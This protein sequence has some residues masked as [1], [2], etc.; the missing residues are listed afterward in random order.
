MIMTS[1]SRL[2]V[3]IASVGLSCASPMTSEDVWECTF[4]GL[5][6]N[7]QTQSRFIVSGQ[8]LLQEGGGFEPFQILENSRDALVAV[9]GGTREIYEKGNQVVSE[10]VQIK[11]S[12]GAFCSWLSPSMA[13]TAEPVVVAHVLRVIRAVSGLNLFFR[14]PR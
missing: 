4:T 7:A 10:L 2:A 12:T 1:L 8:M 14:D 9:W 13:S 6:G 3:A 5:G 11:K